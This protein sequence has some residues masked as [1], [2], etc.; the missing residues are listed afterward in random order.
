MDFSQFDIKALDL[1]FEVHEKLLVSILKELKEAK[2]NHNE[3]YK[4]KLEKIG[5]LL[6]QL[7]IISEEINK[8]KKE[9]LLY[10]VEDIYKFAGQ[11]EKFVIFHFYRTS[12]A[13]KKFGE[14]AYGHLIYKKNERNELEAVIK[15]EKY[16]RTD[17]KIYIEG[18]SKKTEINSLLKFEGFL[19][20]D[21]FEVQTSDALS[22][23]KQ[24]K[25]EGKKEIPNTLKVKFDMNGFD[26]EKSEIYIAL[27]KINDG[28]T[29][30]HHEYVDLFSNLFVIEP[31][32]VTQQMSETYLLAT[33]KKDFIPDAEYKILSAKYR[34]SMADDDEVI[35]L[36]IL[37]NERG[38]KRFEV[39][40][41]E[42]GLSNNQFEIF[43][44]AY[45][46]KF[47][48]LKGVTLMFETETLSN[49]KTT[50]PVY[51]D[52]ERFIHIYLRHYKE[53]F[54]EQST[55]RGTHFQYSYEDIK[56]LVCLIIKNLNEE[57]E[58]ALSSGKGYSKYDDQGYYFNGNFY[59]IRIDK[60]GRLMQFHP[61]E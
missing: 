51:W 43:R 21:V 12:E 19:A 32:T 52:F 4:E 49:Y 23:E 56:R 10:S 22:G 16:H 61:L 18:V 59:A 45:P 29:L 53:F 54:I 6:Y 8:R 26:L 31:E 35:R 33:N 1:L 39:I 28:Y 30:L 47:K 5:G 50:N 14:H 36:N 40:K 27:N 25:K 41:K 9:Q 17:R 55:A 57:I 2:K 60:T 7:K 3:K 11:F 34:R 42:L 37:V 13:F 20:S 44:K 46:E 24:Y 15:N 38:L 58:L 48:E